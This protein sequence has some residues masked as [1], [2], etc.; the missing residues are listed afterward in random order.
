MPSAAH[1]GKERRKKERGKNEL[2]DKNQTQLS[3]TVGPMNQQLMVVFIYG[4]DM[5]SAVYCNIVINTDGQNVFMSFFAKQNKIICIS[6]KQI[7]HKYTCKI[8]LFPEYPQQKNWITTDMLSDTSFLIPVISIFRQPFLAQCLSATKSLPITT[9]LLIFLTS[10][11]TGLNHQF[12]RCSVM[13]VRTAITD[14]SMQLTKSKCRSDIH[15][16]HVPQLSC[17]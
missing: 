14:L 7:L 17:E 4:S 10:Q 9:I 11:I 3:M 15:S 13:G 2:R 6:T 5:R 16:C 8:F 1:R 12:A